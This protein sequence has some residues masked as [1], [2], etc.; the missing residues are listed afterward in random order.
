DNSAT[1][2]LRSLSVDHYEKRRRIRPQVEPAIVVHVLAAAELVARAFDG[3]EQHG[4]DHFACA[5]AVAVDAEE[6]KLAARNGERMR[7]ER[8]GARWAASGRIDRRGMGS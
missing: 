8:G 5:H 6:P 2:L 4:I 1:D 3:C 7:G